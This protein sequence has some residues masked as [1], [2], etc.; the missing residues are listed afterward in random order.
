MLKILRK[1]GATA[2]EHGVAHVHL[3]LANSDS[4]GDMIVHAAKEKKI[5]TICIGRRG[6]GTLSR[7]LLGSG[8]ERERTNLF[9]GWLIFF[10]SFPIRFGT[11]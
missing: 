11:C 5:N 1:H 10:C 8:K 4:P 2:H 7:L 3:L 6:L 9:Y